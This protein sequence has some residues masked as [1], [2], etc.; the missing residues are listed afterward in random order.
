MNNKE[1]QTVLVVDDSEPNIFVLEGALEDIYNVIVSKD[2]ESAIRSVKEN[3]PDLILLDIM[4]PGMDG[5][6]VCAR[7][8]KD[9]PTKDIPIIFITSKTENEDIVN[10]FKL[11]AVDYITK[12]FEPV[13]V[14]ARVETHLALQSARRQLKNQNV[15]LEEKVQERTKEISALNE[16]LKQRLLNSV[17]ILIGLMEGYDPSL[18]SHSKRVA[19]LSLEIAKI[20]EL[21]KE[22]LFHLEIASLLHDIG[23]MSIPERIKASRFNKITKEEQALVKQHTIFAQSVLSP[24]KGFD[25]TGNMIR[26]HLEKIDGSGFPD[27]LIAEKIPICSKI[28]GVANAYDQIRNN[29]ESKAYG[30]SEK[31]KE[32]S[33]L[34]EIGKLGK[35]YYD[36][37]IVK[38]LQTVIS[39]KHKERVEIE[40]LKINELKGG[41]ILAK[42]IYT[43]NQKLIMSK[44][45]TL[46]EFYLKKLDT[47]LNAEIIGE[48]AH[49][50]V[51]KKTKE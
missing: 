48:Y 26:S 40:K 32:D 38:A 17:R 24:S 13:E 37:N 42:N 51:R 31:I 11:G 23:T 5:L 3:H 18:I 27:A 6:E 19:I 30:T 2:G 33:A 34:Q 4:M 16:E 29:I 49:T 36:L 9:E 44:G 14:K 25:I 12:P 15:I 46:N 43:I 50:Y 45:T 39:R 41:M 35:V 1:K 47:F 7:L 10:G 22:E 28:I 8:K 21:P 20:L